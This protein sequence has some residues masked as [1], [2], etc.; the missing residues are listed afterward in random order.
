LARTIIN[1][2]ERVE[3]LRQVENADY[4]HLSLSQSVVKFYK[5]EGIRGL[6]KGN[7]ASVARVFPFSSIEFYSM[8]FYKNMF[9]RGEKNASR[10]NSFGYTFLCGALSGLNAITITFPLDVARTRLSINTPNSNL[11]ETGLFRTIIFLL[12]NEGIK[13]IYKGYS[14]A[15]VVILSF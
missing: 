4:K 12:K 14:F 10:N 13:G 6:L 15:F 11:K 2:I 5:T 9:I 3:I 1:P 7:S 8:E